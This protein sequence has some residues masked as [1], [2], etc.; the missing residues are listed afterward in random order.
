MSQIILLGNTN[1]YTF[2]N[3]IVAAQYKSKQEFKEEIKEIYVIHSKESFKK[4]FVEEEDWINFLEKYNIQV[5]SFI[6]KI[7]FRDNEI[8]FIE[9]IKNI[10]NSCQVD[11]LLIDIS[12]GTSEFKTMLSIVAYVLEISNVYFIDSISLLKRE[13]YK[14]YL[15][16]EQLKDYYKQMINNK[17]IDNLAYLNLTEITRYKEKVDKLSQ[18]YTEFDVNFADASFFKDNLINAI[19][20]K[21]KN[22]NEKVLDNS[23]YRI[24]S[25]AIASSLEDLIDRF[26]LNYGIEEITNKTLGYKIHSLQSKIRETSSSEFDYMFL[27]KFNEFILYLRN[28]TTHKALS[29]SE[30]ERFK[31]SLTLQMSLIFLEY[32][33]TVVR[34]ELKKN[35]DTEI[36]NQTL[37]IEEFLPNT[38]IEIYYGLDGDNTGSVL[39][40]MLQSD[41]SE[42]EIKEFSSK[43]KKAK[44]KIVDYIRKSSKGKVI[45]AEGDDI[46]FKGNFEMIDLRQMLRIYSDNSGGLTC[47]IGY[48]KSLKEVLIAMKFAKIEKNSIKG[49]SINKKSGDR[50]KS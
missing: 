41:F 17:N 20:L 34:Q 23:M 2:C 40:S 35:E 42:T 18:I 32:Y 10:L 14:S 24:S 38:H 22:D 29:I 6:N 43:V 31:A 26:L 9:Y 3:A 48:G 49:I 12:N 30:S 45:F 44:D 47:S 39:E 7:I 5:N 28:S 1:K 13:N 4:L 16:E 36:K 15:E 8:E 27:E 37:D 46:L 50:F 33:S 11:K 21:V 25:T 19:L